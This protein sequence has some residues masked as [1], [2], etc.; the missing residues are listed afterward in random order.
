[1][2]Q[3]AGLSIHLALSR[4]M[5]L[6]PSHGFSFFFYGTEIMMISCQLHRII[7]LNE[8]IFRTVLQKLL[9]GLHMLNKE[10]QL[11]APLVKG[12]RRLRECRRSGRSVG[13][14]IIL[15]T[16]RVKW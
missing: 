12:E 14:L 2:I 15:G 8:K 1:M 6:G 4:C 10:T 3:K 9:H 11:L 7:V 16:P 13:R 5:E